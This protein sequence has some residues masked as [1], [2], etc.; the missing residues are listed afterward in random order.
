MVDTA[1]MPTPSN[2]CT[3]P[4]DHPLLI[5]YFVFLTLLGC[6]LQAYKPWIFP[7]SSLKKEPGVSNRDLSGLMEGGSY[8]SEARCWRDTPP[9]VANSR[10]G[11]QSL[12]GWRRLPVI[13]ELLLLQV[14]SL[15]TR[16]TNRGA[17]PSSP[18]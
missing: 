3:P 5:Y 18:P 13:R 2:S 14:G 4:C 7:A 15:V 6:T 12:G 1:I 9:C 8:M 10:T 11:R 16:E 17:H